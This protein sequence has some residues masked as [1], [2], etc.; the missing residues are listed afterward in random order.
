MLA[1]ALALSL[2]IPYMALLIGYLLPS[3][4]SLGQF[5]V[6]VLHMDVFITTQNCCLVLVPR[7]HLLVNGSSEYPHSKL[8]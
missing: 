8:S 2:P 6:P 3:K 5:L 4:E 7:I 1:L